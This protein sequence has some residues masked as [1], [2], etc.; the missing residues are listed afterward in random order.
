M[1]RKDEASSGK[2]KKKIIEPFEIK[3]AQKDGKRKLSLDV[4]SVGLGLPQVGIR[5]LK[6]VTAFPG[7]NFYLAYCWQSVEDEENFLR[8]HIPGFLPP[9]IILFSELRFFSKPK[10]IDFS[11][12]F[13]I[14]YSISSLRLQEEFE[15]DLISN[16][17]CHVR[18]RTDLS[19]FNAIYGAS[20]CIAPNSCDKDGG[21]NGTNCLGQCC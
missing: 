13:T 1:S 16:L 9:E 8:I 15:S 10:S 19:K 12:Q 7:I 4:N 20:V 5:M 6:A 11:A 17:L 14:R 3:K 18:I 21:D 2:K